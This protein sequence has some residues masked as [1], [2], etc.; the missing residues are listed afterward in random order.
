LVFVDPSISCRAFL[1]FFDQNPRISAEMNPSVNTDCRT[2]RVSGTMHA[3]SPVYKTDTFTQGLQTR[4]GALSHATSFLPQE[5]RT[6]CGC[7]WRYPG[8]SSLCS[9]CTHPPM[10]PRIQLPP[11]CRRDLF[12]WRT[13]RQVR[14][15]GDGR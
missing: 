9:R 15:R 11:Q 3:L 4:K 2:R 5:G 1:L 7:R 14:L 8:R 10:A 13:H 12:G 6:W